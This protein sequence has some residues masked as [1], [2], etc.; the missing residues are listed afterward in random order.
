M[1]KRILLALVAVVALFGLQANAQN[2]MEKGTSIVSGSLGITS[3]LLPIN[4]SYDYGVIDNLFE[5]PNAALSV[6]ALGGVVLGKNTLGYVV[7]PRVAMHYHF[8]PE[9]DTYFS[10]MLGAYGYHYKSS[11]E[12][13][14]DKWT[15]KF[16]WGTHLGARYF[17]TPKV[18]MFAEVGYGYSYA[19][20]GLSFKL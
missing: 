11:G 14:I 20:I 12:V 7:G 6:G 15:H 8:I 10:L 19:N 17:F 5:S 13:S 3:S 18:G 9:L 1:K 16:D 4:A 2:V